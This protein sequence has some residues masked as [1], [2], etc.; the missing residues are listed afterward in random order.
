MGDKS[1]FKG[2]NWSFPIGKIIAIAGANGCGKSSLL[3]IMAGIQQPH[4]GKVLFNDRELYQ[5]PQSLKSSIGYVS[6][7]PMLYP[8]LTVKENLEWI[9]LARGLRKSEC[10]K[11]LVQCDLVAYQHMLFAKLSDGLKKRLGIA[12]GII[13]MPALLIV[14]EPCSALDPLQRQLQ[15]ELLAQLRHPDRLIIFSSHHP[16]E[17]ITWCDEVL[18]LAHGQLQTLQKVTY[19]QALSKQEQPA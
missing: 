13:H 8:H 17:I 11:M 12:V 10:Q 7:T 2:M 4:A 1:F 5:N 14:D 9:A 6:A 15:W 19:K 16:E 3:R 18:I